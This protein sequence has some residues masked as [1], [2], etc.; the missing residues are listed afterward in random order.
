L[1]TLVIF[2]KDMSYKSFLRT[3]SRLIKYEPEERESVLNGTIM[4]TVVTVAFLEGKL[5]R[6]LSLTRVKA[7]NSKSLQTDKSCQ[8]VKET[9]VILRC[10]GN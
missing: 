1:I 9:S 10:Q 3:L 7:F 4:V 6:I 8:G 5:M 2:G